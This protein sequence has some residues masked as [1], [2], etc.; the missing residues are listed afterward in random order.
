MYFDDCQTETQVNAKHRYLA[1]MNHPDH[2]GRLAAM[3]AINVERDQRIEAIKRGVVT[4]QPK[5]QPAKREQPKPKP[6]PKP[7]RQ[8]EP[9]FDAIRRARECLKKKQAE[10]LQHGWWS[11]PWDTRQGPQ[12]LPDESWAAWYS[13]TTRQAFF[14]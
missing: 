13:R 8:S 11:E 9:V 4:P 3:Q 12:P 7:Q 10:A 6:Q 2:G 14:S 5:P 1:L